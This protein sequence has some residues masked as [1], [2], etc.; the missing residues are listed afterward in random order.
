[1]CALYYIALKKTA[2]LAKLYD[3]AKTDNDQNDKIAKLLI[4]DFSDPK[5]KEAALTNA[6]KLKGLHRYELSLA[7]FLLADELESAINVCLVSMRNWQLAIFMARVVDGPDSP[8][9]FKIIEETVLPN[10]QKQKD[11][12]LCSFLRCLLRDKEEL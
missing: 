9:F 1:M 4:N 2:V 5:Y 7:F 11:Q 10:D 12:A 6:Y 3:S 8:L